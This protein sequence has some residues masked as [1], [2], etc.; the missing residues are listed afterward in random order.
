MS[1]SADFREFLES[2]WIV[3]LSE[4]RLTSFELG[5]TLSHPHHHQ[6]LAL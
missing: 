1:R 4:D 3:V 2:F 5:N 6:K